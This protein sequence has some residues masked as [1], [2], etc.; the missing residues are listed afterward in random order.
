MSYNPSRRYYTGSV[1]GYSLGS[2]GVAARE[3]TLW[4]VF[5]SIPPRESFFQGW[6]ETGRETAEDTAAIWNRA[7]VAWW[8]ERSA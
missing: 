6:G 7:E 8:A 1:S 4:Y 5:D 2:G 3:K